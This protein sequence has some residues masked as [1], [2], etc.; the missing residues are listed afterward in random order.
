[1]EGMKRK[2][3]MARC[4]RAEGWC[5]VSCARLSWLRR[6]PPGSRLPRNVRFVRTQEDNNA[7]GR[8]A[9]LSTD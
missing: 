4:Q 8:K 2:T 7:A 5:I 6:C 9:K 1:V 3:Y